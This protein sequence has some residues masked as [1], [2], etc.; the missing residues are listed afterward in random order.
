MTSIKNY[1]E[2]I[3]ENNGIIFS[4]RILKENGG[5]FG[6]KGDVITTLIVNE[7]EVGYF[8]Y[9]IEDDKMSLVDLA[10]KD[11]YKGNKYGNAIITESIRRAKSLNLKKICLEVINSNE[12][13][14]NLYKKYGFKVTEQDSYFL[15][16]TLYI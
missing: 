12:I 5:N 16:M 10:V 8:H 1:I 7:Q 11:K 15:I 14:I 2:Y 9:R 4:D 13:A 3:K 6:I